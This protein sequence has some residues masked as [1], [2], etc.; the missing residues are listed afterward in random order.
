[1]TYFDSIL[2]AMNIKYRGGNNLVA[3]LDICRG[4]N[5]LSWFLVVRKIPKIS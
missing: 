5:D 3:F 1:M 4:K 2:K